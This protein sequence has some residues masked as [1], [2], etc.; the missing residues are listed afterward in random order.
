MSLEI[1]GAVSPRRQKY[2]DAARP[3]PRV[4]N[5]REVAVRKFQHQLE[6][7]PHADAY[8][9]EMTQIAGMALKVSACMFRPILSLN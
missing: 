6:T 5:E 8:A 9:E 2:I 7:A 1:G 3:T 4:V